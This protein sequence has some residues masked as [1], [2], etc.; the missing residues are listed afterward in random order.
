M[1]MLHSSLFFIV[2]SDHVIRVICGMGLAGAD[3]AGILSLDTDGDESTREARSDN[4][5][6]GRP[7]LQVFP[8]SKIPTDVKARTD[9]SSRQ[10]YG[11]EDGSE[12]GT[13]I[14]S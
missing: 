2:K 11:T 6:V 4:Q 7:N 8:V 12:Y 9:G 14:G 1:P 13:D 3:F 5:H 10:E